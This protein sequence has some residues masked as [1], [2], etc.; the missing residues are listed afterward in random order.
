MFS[1]QACVLAAAIGSASADGPVEIVRNLIQNN[2][3]GAPIVHQVTHWD[4]D[5]DVALKRREVFQTV[6]GFR[7][8]KLIERM[9]IGIDGK[10][11][12]RLAEQRARDVGLLGGTIH[13]IKHGLNTPDRV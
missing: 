3:L 11:N 5:P 9:G 2:L 1:V 4:F 13:H 7:G 10:H 6:N 12:E 8:E